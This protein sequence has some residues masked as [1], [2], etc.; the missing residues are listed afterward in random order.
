[1]AASNSLK[2][3]SSRLCRSLFSTHKP[4]SSYNH[5][6]KSFFSTEPSSPELTSDLN[7]DSEQQ[8]TESPVDNSAELGSMPF[9]L[10]SPDKRASDM[11]RTSLEDGLDVGVY[12][13]IIVGQVGQNPMQKKLKNGMTLTLTTVGTGG[14]RN[15]RIPFPSEEPREYAD[16]CNV[17]WHRVTVYPD[18]LGSMI[19]KHAQP[20]TLLYLEGNLETKIFTDPVT[21]LVRRIREIAIRRN[22]RIVFLG[23]SGDFTQ[24]TPNELRGA[25]Y[26]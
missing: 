25:G 19:M 12:K 14:I 6:S 4:I 15:E 8:P 3:I 26:F 24:P 1:M 2:S 11:T 22:G 13:A 5:I 20:G 21:G 9:P 18:R 10:P 17:Q 16:R 23:N 7:F